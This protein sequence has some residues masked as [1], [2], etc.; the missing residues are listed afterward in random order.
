MIINVFVELVEFEDKVRK[1]RLRW[2]GH[3]Q[4]KNS[5]Y[6]GD[7]RWTSQLSRLHTEGWSDKRG[8]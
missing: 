5:G 1:A 2:F 3:V 8:C 6:V 7:E 4:R